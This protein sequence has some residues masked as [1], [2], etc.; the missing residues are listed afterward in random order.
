MYKADLALNNLQ[1]LICH[2]TNPN[3]ISSCWWQPVSHLWNLLTKLAIYVIQT[4]VYILLHHHYW[5]HFVYSNSNIQEF[6]FFFF[7]TQCVKARAIPCPHQPPTKCD[8]TVSVAQGSTATPGATKQLLPLD[9]VLRELYIYI[10]IYARSI[11]SRD[12]IG[13]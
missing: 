5:A 2:K 4:S 7:I 10:Y 13:C 6:F 1:W 11:K 12:Y 8:D 9:R 3:W